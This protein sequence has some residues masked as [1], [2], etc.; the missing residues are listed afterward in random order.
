MAKEWERKKKRTRQKNS[1]V[2]KERAR[3][4]KERY[5]VRGKRLEKSE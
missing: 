4:V 2:W 5:K 3:K 1:G